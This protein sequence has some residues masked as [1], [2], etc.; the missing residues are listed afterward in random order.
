MLQQLKKLRNIKKKQVQGDKEFALQEM[1]TIQKEDLKLVKVYA[2][3]PPEIVFS[4]M[5]IVLV[6]F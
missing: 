6:L 3:R 2:K 4:V 1:K 5:H